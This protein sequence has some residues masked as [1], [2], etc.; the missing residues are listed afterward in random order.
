MQPDSLIVVLAVVPI[1]IDTFI[2]LVTHT[3][4]GLRR[5]FPWWAATV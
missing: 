3:R 4:R 5:E 1:V 2:L